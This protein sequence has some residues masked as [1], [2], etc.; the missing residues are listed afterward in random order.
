MN[1]QDRLK[2]D[3]KQLH[4]LAESHPFNAQLMSGKLKDLNYFVY[5]HNMFP[6]FSYL[7]R[8]MNLSGELVRSPLM[9]CDIMRYSKEGSVI[10]GKDLVYFDWISEI[11]KMPDKMLPAILYVEWL[12]DA[13]GGQMISKYV[14]HNSHLCFNKAKNV[15]MAVRSLIDQ[16]EPEDHDEFVN[17]VN[18]VYENHTK[19]LDKIMKI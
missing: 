6:V 18:K 1:L 2:E 16:V 9:H 5:L 12:K 15:I 11:G 13:Y 17:Q 19:I 7:E 4:D 8:R 3:T 14:K 10:E